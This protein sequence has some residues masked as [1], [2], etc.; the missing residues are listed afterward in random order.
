MFRPVQYPRG[1]FLRMVL[2]FVVLLNGLALLLYVLIK[3]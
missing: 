2:S 1:R 3:S